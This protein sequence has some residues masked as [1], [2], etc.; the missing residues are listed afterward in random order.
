ME[1]LLERIQQEQQQKDSKQ[2]CMHRRQTK[3]IRQSGP[4]EVPGWGSLCHGIANEYTCGCPMG[5][6]SVA[7]FAYNI[8]TK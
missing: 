6:D 2:P 3:K 5:I 4:P 7:A 8:H 1:K